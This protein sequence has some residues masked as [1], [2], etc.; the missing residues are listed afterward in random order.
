MPIGRR[1]SFLAAETSQCIDGHWIGAGGNGM[2]KLS[3]GQGH[4]DL[5]LI[6][7]VAIL[8]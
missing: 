4:A 7:T 5:A 1:S 2:K 8:V 3:L 6:L